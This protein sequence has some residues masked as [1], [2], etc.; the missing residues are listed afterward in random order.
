MPV[1]DWPG[2]RDSPDSFIMGI[3]DITTGLCRQRYPPLPRAHHG[4]EADPIPLPRRSAGPAPVPTDPMAVAQR[5]DAAAERCPLCGM[6]HFHHSRSSTMHC[7]ADTASSIAIPTSTTPRS[8]SSS[9]H[10][11]RSSL[12]RSSP[13]TRP[14][15]RRPP[16]CHCS[17]WDS[18]STVSQASAS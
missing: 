9:P 4:L 5:H 1:A 15:T 16:S 3:M 13:A 2:C 17:T 6:P 11:M 12:S 18:A 14:N 8:L 10:R 7:S